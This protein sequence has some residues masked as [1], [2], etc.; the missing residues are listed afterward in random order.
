MRCTVIRALAA[1][2]ML[3]AWVT[4][5]PPAAAAGIM[6]PQVAQLVA[7]LLPSCV[8]ITTTRYKELQIV[9]GKSV[10]VQDP[11]PDQQHWY[12]SGFIISPDG[13][14]VTNKHVVRNAISYTVTFSDGRQLPA[15]LVEEAVAFDIALLKIRSNETWTPV[16]L[17]DSDTLQRGDPVIAVGNPL[18]YQSTVT[19]GIISAL[20]RDENFTE[21]DDYIQTD[22]AINQGNSGGPL[23]N[24]KGEV[25]G[26]LRSCSR[27]R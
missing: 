7:T 11:S 16:K 9:Q 20:N 19:S 12:G 8:N 1:G 4:T 13:L 21:F 3:M 27:A 18:D 25:I 5:A 15:D 22:A 17:G 26:V 10:M 24:L 2:L 6:D 14:V 23:F